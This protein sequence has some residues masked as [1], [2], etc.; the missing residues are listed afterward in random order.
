MNRLPAAIF[1]AFP[2]L[3]IQKMEPASSR[4]SPFDMSDAAK[5]RMNKAKEGIAGYT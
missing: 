5:G 3:S 2:S 4:S 1:P